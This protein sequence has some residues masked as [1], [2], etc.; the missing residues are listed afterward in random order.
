M[1]GIS[2]GLV[3]G[4]QCPP[5]ALQLDSTVGDTVLY[6]G[7]ATPGSLTSDAVWQIQRITIAGSDFSIEWADGDPD[8]NNVWDD[9]LILAY[10]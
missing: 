2:S 1:G 8:F 10:S 9:R 6:V 4:I 7:K 5:A 3:G